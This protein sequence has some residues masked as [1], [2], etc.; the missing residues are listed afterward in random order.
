MQNIS[1]SHY[2]YGSSNHTKAS[3]SWHVKMGKI[4][5][6]PI[7]RLIQVWP[8]FRQCPN[9]SSILGTTSSQNKLASDWNH[10]TFPLSQVFPISN[11]LPAGCLLPCQ[12]WR[13][14][15]PPQT[16]LRKG[17]LTSSLWNTGQPSMSVNKRG[18]V[19]SGLSSPLH[20]SMNFSKGS[21]CR[22]WTF[23]KPEIEDPNRSTW[24]VPFE[25]IPLLGVRGCQHCGGTC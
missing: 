12:E 21:V 6:R 16:E 19:E 4:H 13:H 11:H 24:M 22:K 17:N 25:E 20:S 15:A 7:Y 3:W 9:L 2:F 1:L 14:T 23:W 10:R 5:K 18:S 8:S